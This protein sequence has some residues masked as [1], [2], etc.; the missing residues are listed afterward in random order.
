MGL[1]FTDMIAYP[2]ANAVV[3]KA[4]NQLTFENFIP[5]GIKLN[6]LKLIPN[7]KIKIEWVGDVV[8]NNTFQKDAYLDLYDYLVVKNIITKKNGIATLFTW[9]SVYTVNPELSKLNKIK[10]LL[11]KDKDYPNLLNCYTIDYAKLSKFLESYTNNLNNHVNLFKGG[12]TR[13][14]RKTRNLKKIK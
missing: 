11:K 13:K 6:I 14:T 2:A 12:K 9:T 5:Q 3:E 8:I 1:S 10:K 4:G 7:C